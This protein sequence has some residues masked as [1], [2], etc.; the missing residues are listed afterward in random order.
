[1]IVAP[2]PG[3]P[4]EVRE[5]GSLNALIAFFAQRDHQAFRCCSIPP[6]RYRALVFSLQSDLE[7]T[8]GLF[9]IQLSVHRTQFIYRVE[10][11]DKVKR[12]YNLPLNARLCRGDERKH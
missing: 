6:I 3:E 4:S 2:K 11:L 5:L 9:A 12:I 1:V 8:S 10:V 7:I